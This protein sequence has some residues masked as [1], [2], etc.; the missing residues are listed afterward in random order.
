L[1]HE[2]AHALVAVERDADAGD[3]ALDYAEEALVVE[4]VTYTVVGALGLRVDD[5]AIPYLASG[6]EDTDL[7]VI[8]QAAG[9]IDRLA[10]RIE[11]SALG[12]APSQAHAD[13]GD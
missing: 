3:V 9:L 11:D 7:A 1:V 2:L 12:A 4:S 6:S 10:R 13:T 5:Y 8:E